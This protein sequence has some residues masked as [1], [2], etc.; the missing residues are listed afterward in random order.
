M[1]KLFSVTAGDMYSNQ[2]RRGT[3]ASDVCMAEDEIEID[4]AV[5]LFITAATTA[6]CR[7]SQ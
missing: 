1:L 6:A 2:H 4:V 3:A 7:H 5:F